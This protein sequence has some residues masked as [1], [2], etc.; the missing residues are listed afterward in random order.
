MKVLVLTQAYPTGTNPYQMMYVHARVLEYIRQ[1][2][3]VTVM[4]FSC[5]ESYVFEGVKVIPELDCDISQYDRVVSHAPNIRNHLR[6][7]VANRKLLNRVTFF[8]HGHEALIKSRYYPGEYSDKNKSFSSVF[9]LGLDY[10]YDLMKLLLLRAFIRVF[11]YKVN[12]VFVSE[13]MKKH[14]EINVGK[15]PPNVDSVV[16]PNS[17]NAIFIKGTWDSKSEKKYDFVSIRPLSGR[18][19]AVDVICQLALDNPE[20]SFLLY[21]RG[22][23][24]DCHTL[25]VNVEWNNGFLQPNEIPRILDSASAALMPTRLDA[26]GVM[27]CEMASYGI[28]LITSELDVCHEVLQGFKEVYFIDNDKPVLPVLTQSPQVVKNNVYSPV[29]L[30]KREIDFI[31]GS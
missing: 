27:M 31:S 20:K 18:K 6:Y 26:Q 3:D 9:K 10:G 11:S 5:K 22:D 14:F 30:A 7:L 24:F 29:S 16:I 23:Y 13:W 17:A 12:L 21:G 28:P 1:S 25:P 19:Y 8:F 4:S 2:V 15:I